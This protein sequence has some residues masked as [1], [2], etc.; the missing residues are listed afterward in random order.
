MAHE[1]MAPS[2]AGEDRV[3]RCSSCDYAANVEMAVSRI[4]RAAVPAERAGGRGRDAQRDDDRGAGAVPR[5]RRAHDRARRCPSSPP[6]ASSGSRSCAA[7]AACT[8]SSS[9][10][11]SSRPRRPAT[12]EEIEA[13]FG[14]KPGSIG[15]V[16][17]RDGRDRRHRRRRDAARGLLGHG[18][19]P[20]RLAPHGRR[21]S[22]RLRGRRS[23][24]CTRS[25]RATAA[26]SATAC[27]RSSR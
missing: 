17:I 25:R 8:S 23:P 10:R 4:E 11:C 22:A 15:P 12:P 26:R 7:T 14:A 21:V 16:G 18:R 13:A 5:H 6:T 27:S 20:H 2:S 9:A 3:A 1:Y 24:T 19:Q